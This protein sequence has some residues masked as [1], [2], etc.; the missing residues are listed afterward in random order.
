MAE[1]KSLA[2]KLCD[3]QMR[4]K[5][6]KDQHNGFGNYN[7]RS[8]ENIL[9]SV[10]PLLHEYG[11]ILTLSDDIAE[12][13]GRVYVKSTAVISDGTD[14]ISTTAFAREDE[15]KKGMSDPQI[16][17]ACSSYARKY[18]AQGLFAIDDS[19]DPDSESYQRRGG[20][21]SGSAPIMCDLCHKPIKPMAKRGGGEMPPEAVAK[22]TRA[23]TGMAVCGD[24]YRKR[25]AQQSQPTEGGNE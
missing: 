8:L 6:P 20:K 11:L 9:E 4:L 3:I 22:W 19:K 2:N 12:V 14:S 10:K 18:C 23:K 5:S 13:G 21:E 16:T 17:G 1:D 24:C 15:S 7:Y 25:E